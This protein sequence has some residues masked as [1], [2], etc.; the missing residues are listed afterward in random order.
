MSDNVHV[1]VSL[2]PGLPSHVHRHRK[3]SY[4]H[5]YVP[6]GLRLECCDLG[7]VSVQ[8]HQKIRCRIFGLKDSENTS[9]FYRI[10]IR[11]VSNLE[12]H[13]ECRGSFIT[14]NLHPHLIVGDD[15][16]PGQP[17]DTACDVHVYI[18]VLCELYTYTCTHLHVCTGHFALNAERPWL[19][20]LARTQVELDEDLPHHA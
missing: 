20:G 16:M 17:L 19:E 12:R 4:V 11:R 7:S 6:P 14:P 15:S 10:W 8:S 9:I 5:V 13:F 3:Q 2:G 1:H 18:H